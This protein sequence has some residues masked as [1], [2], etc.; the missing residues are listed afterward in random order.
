[1]AE[2]K[3]GDKVRL[4]SGGPD[5]TVKELDQLLAIDSDDILCTWFAGLKIQSGSFPPDT[6]ERVEDH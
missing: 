6:L 1:M 5:M 3:V 2:F 4:K